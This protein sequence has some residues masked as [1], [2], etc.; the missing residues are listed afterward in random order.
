MAP[1]VEVQRLLGLEAH[2]L[3]ARDWDA[4]LGLYTNDA[5][6]WVPAWDDDGRLTSDPKSELSLM[7]YNSRTGLEERVDRIRNGRSAA[8]RP[9]PRTTHLFQLLSCAE[10]SEEISAH[11]SWITNSFSDGR[12]TTYFGK[13]H[14]RFLQFG[15]QLLVK[16]KKTIINN[17][18]IDSVADIYSI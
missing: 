3:D 4:W 16:F 10:S 9:M 6:Y 5:E 1:W 15:E 17:D 8:S 14:Y 13:A 18:I 12:V 7:Y 11:T 2:Y